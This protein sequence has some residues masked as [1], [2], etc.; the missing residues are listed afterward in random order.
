MGSAGLRRR[1]RTGVGPGRA[2]HEQGE[3]AGGQQ[4][5]SVDATGRLCPAGFGSGTP[6]S[7][8]GG[9]RAER[10]WH[11]CGAERLRFPLGCRYPTLRFQYA[12]QSAG[13]RH[14]DRYPPH[15]R[16]LRSAGVGR[17]SDAADRQSRGG[18]GGIVFRQQRGPGGGWRGPGCQSE[19]GPVSQHRIPLGLRPVGGVRRAGI[20][21]QEPAAEIAHPP[22]LFVG[23]PHS[24]RT[25]S[26]SGAHRRAVSG[27]GREIDRPTE[28]RRWSH[29]EIAGARPRLAPGSSVGRHGRPGYRRHQ[30]QGP[31][32]SI[33]T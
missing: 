16:Q 22:R 30:E 29:R 20:L 15:Y 25:V 4:R 12:R 19:V 11:R 32:R 33:S 26:G 28:D 6:G 2:Q 27:A 23:L 5:R 21:R 1:G 8:T 9:F 18:G 3:I 17:C 7:A 10:R 24:P 14:F 31:I 13:L